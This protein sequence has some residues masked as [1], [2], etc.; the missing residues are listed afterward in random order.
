MSGGRTLEVGTRVKVRTG[1]FAGVKGTMTRWGTSKIL[2]VRLDVQSIPSID[3]EVLPP[4]D[5]AYKPD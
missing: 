3:L 5:K 1:R 4:S 2:W